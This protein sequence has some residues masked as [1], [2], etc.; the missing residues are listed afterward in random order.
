MRKRVPHRIPASRAA[1]PHA[2][3]AGRY[4][5]F[6]SHCGITI[7]WVLGRADQTFKVKVTS[8]I[9]GV[10]VES[11]SPKVVRREPL[12]TEGW[13]KISVPL[14]EVSLSALRR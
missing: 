14:G 4:Y 3:K 7:L 10:I 1:S 2:R 5:S 6:D 12:Q 9:P 8:P 13:I 11:V